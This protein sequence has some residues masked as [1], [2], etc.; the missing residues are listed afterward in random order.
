M[1]DQ[2]TIDTGEI[3]TS[4]GLIP[5][6]YADRE[7][8]SAK[9]ATRRKK[10][11][12]ARLWPLMQAN[13]AALVSSC[14]IVPSIATI[15]TVVLY[16]VASN[17]PG[18]Q[19][20][21]WSWIVTGIVWLA[22]SIPLSAFTSAK[23]VNPH[24]YGLIENRL[25]RLET[26]LYVLQTTTP[27]DQL[28]QYQRV[29]L[30]EAYDN[31]SKLQD[32]MYNST[33]RLPWVLAWGYINAWNWLHRTE[34][35]LIE[36]EPIEMV[37]GGAYHDYMA[38]SDSKM[39]NSKDLLSNL[40]DATKALD[41]K[42]ASVFAA[43]NPSS[44]EAE[45]L[46]EIG[47]GVNKIEQDVHRIATTLGVQ[48]SDSDVQSAKT[49]KKNP[50][51]PDKEANARVTIR[52]I[53]RA[54]NEFRDHQRLGIVHVRNQLM[55]NIFFTGSITYLLLCVAILPVIPTNSGPQP[56]RAT[57][58]AAVVF[59]IVGAIFGLFGTILR[60]SRAST[61]G[62]DY[63]LSLVR[64]IST[65]L[66]SGLAGIGGAFLYNILILQGAL[67]ASVSLSTV[68][69]INRLDYLIAAAIFGYAPNL[70]L[71][72]LQSNKYVSALQSSETSRSTDASTQQNETN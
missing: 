62:D 71:K 55:A 50:S 65:P 41:P 6:N 59:Y 21:A 42:F 63:G 30:E 37:V 4:P 52:Q 34:E 53:R 47:Q 70:L 17:V 2:L 67:G 9:P 22:L 60:Q 66:I 3:T 44:V 29:A 38:I 27:E 1:E 31:L 43:S 24:N 12:F 48:L 32:L 16:L 5:Q 49:N 8:F 33:S 69:T 7:K 23:A 15:F 13:G 25:S 20:V 26:R 57:I 10:G 36:I 58:L 35:A 46:G 54:L 18:W 68:F 19:P 72:G 45:A 61:G 40:T 39:D 28:K 51:T 14:A 56:E 64:L 11:F